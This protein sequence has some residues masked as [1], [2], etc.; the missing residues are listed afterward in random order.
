MTPEGQWAGTPGPG[1][2]LGRRECPVDTVVREH[3]FLLR[4]SLMKEKSP[5]DSANITDLA[6][7]RKQFLAATSGMDPHAVMASLAGLGIEPDPLDGTPLEL[8]DPPASPSRYRVRI[9]LVGAKPPIWRRMA[10]PGDLTL[11]QVHEAI[12]VAFAWTDSHL[13]RFSPSNDRYGASTEAIVTQCDIDEGENG[14]LETGVRLDQLIQRAGDSFF[15]TYDFGDDWE[16]R[17]VVEEVTELDPDE[18]DI[19]CLDGRREA[20]PEDSGGIHWYQHLRDVEADA[21]HPDRADLAE[22]LDALQPEAELDLEAVNHGLVR[23]AG[24]DETLAWLRTQDSPLARLILGL[25]PEAQRFLAGY[26]TDARLH[27]PVEV[28]SEDAERATAVL[29]T[30]LGHLRGGIRLTVAG[31]LPPSTV[32]AVMHDL[33]P[34][35]YWIGSP[36][37]EAGIWP[38]IDLRETVTSLGLVRKY[39]GDLLLTKQG[40]KLHDDPVGLWRYLAARLPVERSEHEREVGVLLLLLLAA[41]EPSERLDDAL[42]MLSSVIG[43]RFTGGS[44]HAQPSAIRV[45][46]LTANTLEWSGTGMFFTRR[47]AMTGP[48]SPEARSMARAALTNWA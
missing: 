41:G 15:Y 6:V 36:N 34:D 23:L 17:I 35:G 14:L 47:S 28:S 29:R 11:D 33:D 10:L 22:Q 44:P 46:S 1:A 31:Y 19:R 5:E 3:G 20:P 9:D 45:V 21:R 43:L 39:R 38:L 7:F 37:R 16:H 24:A 8:P 4:F 18:R 2:D 13:H 25:G 26:V 27:E 48:A 42:A 12:Q 32:G 40:V 30:F